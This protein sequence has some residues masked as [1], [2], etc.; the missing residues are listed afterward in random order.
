MFNL[1]VCKLDSVVMM[2]RLCYLHKEDFKI[3]G[4][5]Q[6]KKTGFNFKFKHKMTHQQVSDARTF[7][8]LQ[9][10]TQQLISSSSPRP[11]NSNRFQM[12]KRKRVVDDGGV[13]K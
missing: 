9:Q 5:Q 2:N 12:K 4:T 7:V 1:F 3:D 6:H 10:S 8:V 13:S 11:S